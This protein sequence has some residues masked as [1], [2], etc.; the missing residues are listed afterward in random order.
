MYPDEWVCDPHDDPAAED[1]AEEE[2]DDRV[3]QH[4]PH[5]G[6]HALVPTLLHVDLQLPEGEGGARHQYDVAHVEDV[7]IVRLNYV[8]V[9]E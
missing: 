6:R 7:L 5:V 3:G 1:H 2:V 8:T 9:L 4:Q